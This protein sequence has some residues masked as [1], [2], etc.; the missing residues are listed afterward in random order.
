MGEESGSRKLEGL[1]ERRYQRGK[2]E[3]AEAGHELTGGSSKAI[4]Y[5]NLRGECAGIPVAIASSAPSPV[6]PRGPE[7]SGGVSPFGL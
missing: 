7:S 4:V 5:S 3:K 6:E 2:R 1:I